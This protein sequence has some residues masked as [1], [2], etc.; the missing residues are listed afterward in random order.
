MARDYSY[1]EKYEA[2]PEQVK[3]REARNRARAE[4]KKKLGASAIKGKDIDHIKPLKDGGSTVKGKNVRVRSVHS[5][6]GD[7]N[8]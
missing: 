4:E 8:F 2:S 5:N 6:R 3:H 7:K 1:D